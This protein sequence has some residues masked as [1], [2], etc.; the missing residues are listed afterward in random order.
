MSDAS[1]SY[2]E[3]LERT[4]KA[5]QDLS[6]HTV[7]ERTPVTGFLNVL[8]VQYEPCEIQK[9][10]PEPI[11]IWFRDARFQVTEILDEDRRRDAELRERE[12]N[13]RR[14]VDTGKFEYFK[15]AVERP[16][17]FRPPTRCTPDDYFQR[18]LSRSEEK[19]KKY[20][21]IDGGIDLLVYIN[22]SGTTTIN[23]RGTIR[24]ET[25][26]WPDL[27]PLQNHGWRS[28]SFVDNACARVL[29][30]TENAPAFLQNAMGKTHLWPVWDLKIGSMFPQELGPDEECETKTDR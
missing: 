14:A 16:G 3:E 4:K 30:A 11:D 13:L 12:D 8:G 24:P 25:E 10:G 26:P 9:K 6:N 1:Q 23:L 19:L 2:E 20:G 21:R 7:K 22:L 17:P 5:R 15:K 29:Y 18:I 28:V 27:A